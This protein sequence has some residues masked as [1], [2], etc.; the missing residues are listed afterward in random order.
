MMSVTFESII[1]YAFIIQRLAHM[2]LHSISSSYM[3]TVIVLKA[4]IA[5]SADHGRY[6]IAPP[7]YDMEATLLA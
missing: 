1:A 2:H 3:M 5:R 4:N 6:L 7:L